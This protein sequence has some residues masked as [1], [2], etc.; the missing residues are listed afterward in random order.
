MKIWNNI[1][2]NDSLFL[3][4]IIGFILLM[5]FIF[6]VSAITQLTT[7]SIERKFEEKELSMWKRFPLIK[8]SSPGYYMAMFVYRC[9]LDSDDQ[10]TGLVTR[11]GLYVTQKAVFWWDGEKWVDKYLSRL[12]KT[13]REKHN[14]TSGKGLYTT[15]MLDDVIKIATNPTIIAWRNLPISS[16]FVTLEDVENKDIITISVKN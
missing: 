3:R 14:N 10:I 15:N 2:A 12:M 4:I 8:P 6:I 16:I 9:D 5:L 1:V 13:A 7:K 11:K